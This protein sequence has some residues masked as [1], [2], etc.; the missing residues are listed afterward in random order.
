MLGLPSF[1]GT[2]CKS[3]LVG[4]PSFDWTTYNLMVVL[5]S[6]V[7]TICKIILLG[8]PSFD[9]T[10]YNLMLG[11]PTFVGYHMIISI[12]SYLHHCIWCGWVS[13]I[14]GKLIRARAFAHERLQHRVSYVGIVMLSR[15]ILKTM[16]RTISN[17][18]FNDES[19]SDTTRFRSGTESN[20]PAAQDKSYT[21][22]LMPASNR[23]P[24]VRRVSNRW[25]QAENLGEN[26]CT[27]G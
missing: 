15:T 12:I 2:T 9:R 13:R 26:H 21:S 22:Q 7:G 25:V 19:Q 8:L 16:Y 11:L 20:L 1:V 27:I 10:T 14:P 17:S 6:F 23:M 3:I 5:P 4:L 18:T 24:L